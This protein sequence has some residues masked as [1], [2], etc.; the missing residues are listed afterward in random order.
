MIL[1]RP[2]RSHTNKR[3]EPSWG[4][5]I[6]MGS[7]KPPATSTKLIFMPCGNLPPG[8]AVF[9]SAARAVLS[10]QRTPAKATHKIIGIKNCPK[11]EISR[12]GRPEYTI[13]E[14]DEDEKEDEVRGH[15]FITLAVLDRRYSKPGP[16][17]VSKS[18]EQNV[19]GE[20]AR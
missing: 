12:F 15:G 17:R 11:S 4:L 19:R 14:E 7:T 20:A 18:R 5:A 10:G 13:E 8:R 3:P 16:G 6:W 9:S 1:M 2:G